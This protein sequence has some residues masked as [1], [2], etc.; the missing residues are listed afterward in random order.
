[1][2]LCDLIHAIP[3]AREFTLKV[4]WS[5]VRLGQLAVNWSSKTFEAKLTRLHWG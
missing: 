4:S 3:V 1:L 5:L 2:N